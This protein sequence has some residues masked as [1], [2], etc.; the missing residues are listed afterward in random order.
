MNKEKNTVKI[1]VL[2]L[3]FIPSLTLFWDIVTAIWG[4]SKV[5]PA[6]QFMFAA[7]F[8]LLSI[9][10]TD[11]IRYFDE[12]WKKYQSARQ[13]FEKILHYSAVFIVWL[14]CSPNLIAAL[15]SNYHSDKEIDECKQ[16]ANALINHYDSASLE[17]RSILPSGALALIMLLLVSFNVFPECVI[18]WIQESLNAL[19]SVVGLLF[20][21]VNAKNRQGRAEENA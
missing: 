18:S 17:V 21:I 8:T 7:Y 14:M 15:I 4:S 20:V 19:V 1:V 10:L 16:D 13:V 2:I 5:Y 3:T 6:F 11:D 9:F 12:F